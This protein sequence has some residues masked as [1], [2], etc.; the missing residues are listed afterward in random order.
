MP[1][2][3]RNIFEALVVDGIV[4]H[5]SPTNNFVDHGFYQFSPTLYVDYYSANGFAD[6]DV[7]VARIVNGVTTTK[8]YHSGLL[9]DL[10]AGGRPNEIYGTFGTRCTARKLAT[11]TFDRIPQQG[12]YLRVWG[13]FANPAPSSRL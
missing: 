12:E 10:P 6:I 3:L 1:N 11:T 9:A 8:T 7:S 2:L 4:I 5:H 13:D